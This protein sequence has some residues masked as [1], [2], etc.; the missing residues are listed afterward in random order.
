M[1]VKWDKVQKI[2]KKDD[3]GKCDVIADPRSITWIVR[4]EDFLVKTAGEE[5]FTLSTWAESQLCSRLGMPVKYFRG[6]PAELKKMQVE[7]LIKNRLEAD[8]HWRLR[9]RDNVIRGL[10]SGSYQPFDNRTVAA[11]WEE[12]G[13]VGSF[14]YQVLLDDTCFY[15][16]AVLPNGGD[17]NDD[18]GGLRGGFYIRNSEVGRSG[19]SAGPILFRLVCS[20][21]L[22]VFNDGN[23][24]MYKRHIW[25]KEYA[26]AEMLNY[27]FT[28]SIEL[29]RNTALEMD[30]ARKIPVSFDTLVHKLDELELEERMRQKVVD[31]FIC[32]GHHDAF[33]MVNAL[34]AAARDLLPSERFALESSAGRLLAEAS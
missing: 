25:I 5:P 22:V 1:V 24:F 9:L 3:T 12:I 27:A 21:G 7:Y 16:Q 29:A 6:C 15:L 23:P 11:V 2:I 8:Q 10:V 34:T 26:I 14:D 28:G 19:L 31:A 33:G 18:L 4:G 32:E 17:A 20:N 30:K 13:K